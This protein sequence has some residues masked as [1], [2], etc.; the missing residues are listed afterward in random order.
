[1]TRIEA[2]QLPENTQEPGAPAARPLGLTYG[3]PTDA[4]S[5]AQDIP[6]RQ[7]RLHAVAWFYDHDRFDAALLT[8]K[9][10]MT[11]Y[12]YLYAETALVERLLGLYD[13]LA[14]Y[15][16]LLDESERLLD[17]EV[18]EPYTRLVHDWHERAKNRLIR[19]D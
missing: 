1:M 3:R 5:A 19:P 11:K 8:L 13:H 9:R 17:A 10:A 4:T 16:F 14:L 6:Y 18:S 15:G 12:P 7:E 2:E